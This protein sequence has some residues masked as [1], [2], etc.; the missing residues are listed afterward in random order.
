[1]KYSKTLKVVER[2][3]TV[4]ERILF[5]AMWL[6]LAAWSAI[7]IA[8]YGWGVMTAFKTNLDY[9]R[10]PL[11]FPELNNLQWQNFTTAI[12][13]MNHNG[14]GFVGMLFNSIWMVLGSTLLSTLSICT[15]GYIMAQ[16]EFKGKGIIMG[17]VIFTMIIP[18]YGSLPA[19]Y[20]LIY[21]LGIN[22]SP[23]YLITSLG[24][25][26]GG[27]MMTY[28]FYNGLSK[29]YREA[30]YLDGGG[31]FTAYINI[32]LPMGR[33][34]FIAMFLNS[35]ITHWNDYNT[36][37]LYFDK[38]PTLASGMFY[39]QEEIKY[40]ANNPAFFAGAIIMMLPI[41]ILF[42]TCCDKIMGKMYSGGLKG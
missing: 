30:I 25:I 1:M 9:I 29:N 18:I 4:G 34:I 27:M 16:Y 5:A 12:K 32:G 36:A 35:T 33:S 38:M 15:V 22:D 26:G 24:G 21:D 10:E 11:K 6:I 37:L 13:K 31:E 8:M 40:A 19:T 42:V 39:F 23:L 28:A 17:V 7:I 3:K 41:L 14:V 2:R 20:K